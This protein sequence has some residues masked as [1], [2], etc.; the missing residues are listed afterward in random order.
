MHISE[1]MTRD[2]VVAPPDTMLRVAAQPAEMAPSYVF[3]A[4][5]DSRYFTGDVLAPTGMQTTSR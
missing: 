3:L 2:P 5:T 1:I 4:S